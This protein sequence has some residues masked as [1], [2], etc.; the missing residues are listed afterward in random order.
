MW[1]YLFDFVELVRRIPRYGDLPVPR[2]L[3]EAFPNLSYVRVT[4]RDKVRQAV[5]LW[6][7]VQT[8]AW[9][10]DRDAGGA[11]A[12]A[13]PPSYDFTAIHH[14]VNQLHAHDNAWTGYFTG[15]GVPP[16]TVTYEELAED[17][18]GSVR[19][20]LRHLGIQAPAEGIALEPKLSQ[21]ADALSE[22]WV[23][24][25]EEQRRRG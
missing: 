8:Q 5:S 2:L 11:Q 20:V 22:E 18:E 4:R 10:Q 7:A 21:Q 17:K 23:A 12:A 16:V 24:R 6:K 25:Y 9:R 3:E 1:G 13:E 19:R 15:L 14:L